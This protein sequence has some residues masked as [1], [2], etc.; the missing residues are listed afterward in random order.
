MERSKPPYNLV[1]I[2][3]ENLLTPIQKEIAQTICDGKHSSREAIAKHHCIEPGTVVTHLYGQANT[4]KLPA[5][6][7]SIL[8][9]TGVISNEMSK[10]YN[11]P[12]SKNK[13]GIPYYLLKLGIA[14]LVPNES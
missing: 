6:S 5:D 8:G 12:M 11:T 9:I 2:D 3:P 14:E 13:S 7:P 1:V 4:R 10:K